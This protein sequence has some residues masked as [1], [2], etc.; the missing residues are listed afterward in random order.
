MVAS[1]VRMCEITLLQLVICV[2]CVAVGLKDQGKRD[3]LKHCCGYAAVQLLVEGVGVGL[4]C[5][6][7][8]W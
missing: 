6:R 4:Y 5:V 2:G 3:K 7:K 1:G 8:W